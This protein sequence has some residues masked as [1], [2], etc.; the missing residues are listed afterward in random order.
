MK[1]N[2]FPL[3]KD[4]GEGFGAC[5]M[6]DT[7]S[8]VHLTVYATV[9][10]VLKR[11]GI[12][13]LKVPKR[14]AD[15]GNF[16]RRLDEFY[17]TLCRVERRNI[18]GFRF[19]LLCDSPCASQAASVFGRYLDPAVWISSNCLSAHAVEVDVYLQMIHDALEEFRYLGVEWF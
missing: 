6:R 15:C 1:A 3:L 10:H 13:N 16:L 18:G 8:G 19:E 4:L 11:H 9:I 7:H 5:E 12:F 17:R 14:V 2:R